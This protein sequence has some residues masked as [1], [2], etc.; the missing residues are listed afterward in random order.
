MGRFPDLDADEHRLPEGMQRVGYDADTECYTF[1][2]AAGKFFES[3]RGSRYGDLRPATSAVPQATHD[4]P[5]EDIE[6]R[7]QAID[8]SNR[9]AV[10]AMLPFALLVFVFLLVVLRVVNG[11]FGF[12]GGSD[13]S[14]AGHAA[15]QADIC[16]A[17][18]RR[19]QVEKGDTCWAIAEGCSLT[20][21]ELLRIRGNDEVNCDELPVGQGICVPR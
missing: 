4:T 12:W 21:D 20:V 9:E 18:S 6:Q 7:N 10:R 17:G 1:R 14:L 2:D 8:Q 19:L 16:H 3:A 15:A 5:P 11:G 13:M